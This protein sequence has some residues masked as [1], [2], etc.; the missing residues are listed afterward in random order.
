MASVEL[1]GIEKHFDDRNVVAGVSLSVQDGEFVAILGPSGCGKSTLLRIIAGLERATAGTVRIGDVDATA[2]HPKD[3]NIAMV[4][5]NYALYPH[6]TVYENI[7]FPLRVHRAS[8]R[9]VDD[10]VRKTAELVGITHLLA[11]KPRHVSGGERQR[12]ALAR[13]LVRDPA[14]FL[15]DEPL[16]NLD[17]KLRQSAREDL[18]SLQRTTGL[19]ALY[20]THDQVEAMGLGD[21]IVVMQSGR[22]RQIGTPDQIYQHPADTFVATF[23]GTPPMNLVELDGKLVGFRPESVVFGTTGDGPHAEIPVRIQRIEY[24]GSVR[25]VYAD[26]AQPFLP[27]RVIA[28][29]P[30]QTA[31]PFQDGDDAVFRVPLAELRYFDKATGL[32]DTT[33][34]PPPALTISTSARSHG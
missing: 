19:T 4:F 10:A 28:S 27:T 5:Q 24:L 20:V 16:S 11:R 25:L 3:R 1:L 9:S 2:L 29:L 23:I 13:A 26:V 8:R 22:I 18:K 34:L 15:L 14:L 31:P 17:A 21:R 6:L 7:A 33:A 12:A 30:F 32:A